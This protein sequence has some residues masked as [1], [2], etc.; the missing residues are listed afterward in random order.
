MAITPGAASRMK[1]T[2]AFFEEAL[3]Q[4]RRLAKMNVPPAELQL[5]DEAG[6]SLLALRMD[7]ELLERPA[8]E[9]MVQP[10]RDA[11]SVTEKAVEELRRIIAVL[12][13][14]VFERLGL[15]AALKQLAGRFERA[16]AF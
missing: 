15:E 6:Q 8:P 12:S 1:S 5:H 3:E 11:R 14:A 4:G 13:P 2:T 7:L 9:P 10:L 16:T